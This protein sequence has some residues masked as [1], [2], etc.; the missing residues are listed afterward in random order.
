MFIENLGLNSGKS[1][2][3]FKS[4]AKSISFNGMPHIN[5]V[6][7]SFKNNIQIVFSD[8][9]G[10]ISKHSDMMSKKTIDT[11]DFLHENNVPVVLTTARCYQDTLPILQQFSHRPDYTIVLQGG[12][13]VN[14]S[15]NSL[16]ENT[17]SARAGKKLV[18]WF[19]SIRQNDK[20]SHLI[21][22]FNEQPY[23]M[24][25]I[26][27]P[28]KS[29]A[30][31]KQVNSFDN[32]FEQKKI[33]QKAIIYKSDA[34]KCKNYNPQDVI[35]SFKSAHISDLDIKASGNTL[36]FQNKW[37]SKDKAI[38]FLLRAL[39]IDPKNAMVIGD[40]AND[41]E[42]MDFIRKQNGLA[43]AMGNADDF[44]KSHANA[45]TSHID[46]DGFSTAVGK[47]FDTLI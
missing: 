29:Y 42:M 23:A 10:T 28:W 33:L 35:D 40:S 4:G 30:P 1:S 17:I 5:S 14:G 31:I 3:N 44:V 2:Y 45:I 37:V 32:L 15:G 46:E 7:K 11:V 8:I 36:E 6:G 12:G 43:V 38:D 9:D 18:K 19:K 39:K 47:I 25:G 20:N 27:F 16:F 41:I 22:Y 24:S 26:Q 13:L 34:S 21:M